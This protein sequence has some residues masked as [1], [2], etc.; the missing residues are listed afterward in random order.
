MTGGRAAARALLLAVLLLVAGCGLSVPGGVH[1][2]KRVGGQPATDSGVQV[3][4]AGPSAGASPV[5]VVRGFL[6][7]HAAAAEGDDTVAREYLAP[8][9]VW[10]P[11]TGTMVLASDPTESA[12]GADVIRVRAHVVAEIDAG[13][14]RTAADRDL[15]VTVTVAQ[16]GGQWRLAS[17]P[18]G[19]LL[20]T[21]DADRALPA[22][23]LAWYLPGFERLMAEPVHLRATVRGRV[24]ALVRAL[25]AG[26]SGS[27]AATARTALP[28]SAQLVEANVGADGLAEIDL[29]PAIGSAGTAQLR[30]AQAQLA[31]ALGQLTEVS[32]VR[33]LAGGIVPPGLSDLTRRASPAA[34]TL[35]PQP[36]GAARA[37]DGTAVATLPDAPTGTPA[38]GTPAPLLPAAC[39]AL[40]VDQHEAAFLLAAPGGCEVHVTT[41]AGTAL[42]LA[43][44]PWRDVALLPDGRLLVAGS[45]GL[46]LTAAPRVTAASASPGASA[47]APPAPP[48][49]PVPVAGLEAAGS[50]EHVAL[51]PD[52]GRVLLVLDGAS[53]RQAAWGLLD[54][55]GATPRVSGLRPVARDVTDV[56]SAGWT[57]SITA[58]LVGHAA[59]ASGG[60]QVATVA[61]DGSGLAI[62]A[63]P[64]LP[65]VPTQVAGAPGAALLAVVNGAVWQQAAGGWRAL[66]PGTAVAYP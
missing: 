19:L 10:S 15:D 51:A 49:P 22:L 29:G 21:R 9:A 14:R 28:S 62:V 4:P 44:G 61:L 18:P 46:L 37:L 20:T 36:A 53:G 47:T 56:T 30:L 27:V 34:F 8:T 6:A 42:A 40:A 35:Y 33:L 23:A 13:G 45:T 12:E 48:A 1:E 41:A 50:V 65:A 17:V 66:G 58:V 11:G 5:A 59:S 43:A 57:G 52:G 64:G 39:A 60:L 54:A 38:T 2:L 63:T 3:L 32:G 25:L 24:P 26:P 31:A 55:S 16:Q 7:A